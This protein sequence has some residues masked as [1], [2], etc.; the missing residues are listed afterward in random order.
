MNYPVES[1]SNAGQLFGYIKQLTYGVDGL[2]AVLIGTSAH[3][4]IVDLGALVLSSIGVVGIGAYP[5]ER[6]EATGD[7]IHRPSGN[8][9][10]RERSP[11]GG[12]R[13]A[14]AVNESPHRSSF[15][16]SGRRR[17]AT[18]S[19]RRSVAIVPESDG[20]SSSAR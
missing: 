13:H 20:R 2:R 10:R 8:G 7:R 17:T 5:F 11:S 3:P 15:A 1:L 12:R 16:W 18:A 9:H 6:V 4:P 14:L 19:D